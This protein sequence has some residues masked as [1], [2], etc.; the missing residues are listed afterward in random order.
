[1]L[2]LSLVLLAATAA[3]AA[4]PWTGPPVLVT[5]GTAEI[6]VPPDRAIVRFTTEARAPSAKAAQEAE[7][8]AM[9]A[10]QK[11]LAQAHIPSDATRTLGYELQQEFGATSPATR[12]RY[13]W[14]TWVCWAR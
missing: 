12:W 7:A 10:L 11:T 4:E 5:T 6:R 3:Y 13:G 9:S 1:M 14:T 8:A 2:T